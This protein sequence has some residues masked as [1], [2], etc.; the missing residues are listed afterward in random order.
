[1]RSSKSR[2]ANEGGRP[3][4]DRRAE[5]S[6]G[7]LSSAT[8]G[9]RVRERAKVWRARR[10]AYDGL[11]KEWRAGLPGEQAGLPAEQAGAA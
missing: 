3:K 10:I 1:M 4:N 7:A 2:P 6:D 9:G 8:S 5:G 11:K